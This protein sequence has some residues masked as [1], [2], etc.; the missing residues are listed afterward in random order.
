MKKDKT[1]KSKAEETNDK[2]DNTDP[3]VAIQSDDSPASQEELKKAKSDYLYLAAEFENYKRNAIR[4]RADLVRYAGER[5]ARE[6]LEVSDNF[7]RALAMD[8]TAENVNVFRDGVTLIQ[9]ELAALLSRHNIQEIDPLGQPFDPNLH[10]A[11]T[12][13]ETDKYPPG[14]ISRVFKKAYRLHDRLIRPAQV[15]VAQAPRQGD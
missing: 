12:S 11:L 3:V 6:L 15:V 2:L 1:D 8:V 5:L 9:K 14:T 13:E 7:A 4:E 10:E